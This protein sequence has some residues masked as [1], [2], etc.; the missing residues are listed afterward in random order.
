MIKSFP[1]LP[2]VIVL[3]NATPFPK[4]LFWLKPKTTCYN[5]GKEGHFSGI[6][7]EGLSVSVF[8]TT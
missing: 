4:D 2:N 1:D 8:S 3:G 6:N 7:F 5:K